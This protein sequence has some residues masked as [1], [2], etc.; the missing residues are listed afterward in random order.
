M[1]S[2]YKFFAYNSIKHVFL[3]KM[4]DLWEFL[5]SGVIIDRNIPTNNL[6]VFNTINNNNTY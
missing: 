1:V 6:L 4:C 3:N 2:K 5:T